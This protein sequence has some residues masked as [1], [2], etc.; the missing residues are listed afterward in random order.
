MSIL[1]FG[2]ILWDVYP[3]KEVIGGAP[4]NFAAHC[5][6]LGVNASIMSAVGNDELGMKTA[7]IVKQYGVISD[8]L[9][10]VDR[11]TGVCCVTVD[12]VGIPRYDLK[13][14]VA[15]DYISFNEKKKD[16]INENYNV[17]YFGTLAQRNNYSRFALKKL[18]D[19][20]KFDIVM[21][22]VNIRQS[23]YDKE[24][25]ESGL[26]NCNILKVSEEEA[27]VFHKVGIVAEYCD[28][29]EYL[30]TLCS[31]L[32]KKY[33]IEYVLLTMGKKGAVVY[34]KS[35]EQFIYSQ[36]PESKAVST[37]GA[38][39]S[40]AAAF[41]CSYIS[42]ED[43]KSCINKAILLS[44]YVVQKYEAIPEYPESLKKSLKLKM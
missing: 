2:E 37:V 36:I 33:S 21:F 35:Q 32:S 5:V 22:D 3:D 15:Y 41:L 9:S 39:D 7:E 26:Y 30:E 11:P 4:F 19:N 8:F 27:D 43:I 24:I 28:S 10:V 16:L 44:D 42:G 17:L 38:G 31:Y 34:S 13:F 40:F 12:K 18:I 23:F 29:E 25:I 6:K 1:S 20:C 14:G